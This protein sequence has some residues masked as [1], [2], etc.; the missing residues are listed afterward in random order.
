MKF[1][2][3]GTILLNHSPFADKLIKSLN[4]ETDF[5]NPSKIYSALEGNITQPFLKQFGKHDE[6]GDFL[7]KVK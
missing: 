6:R 4:S 7:L 2:I 5:I 1:R 3:I